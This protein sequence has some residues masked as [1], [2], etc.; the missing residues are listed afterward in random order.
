MVTLRGN[1]VGRPFSEV[2]VGTGRGLVP[3][4]GTGAK[5]NKGLLSSTVSFPVLLGGPSENPI[6]DLVGIIVGSL[7]SFTNAFHKRLQT[8]GC[9]S[10]IV[11]V[12][13]KIYTVL[14]LCGRF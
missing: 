4:A 8:V 7:P 10:G 12:R 2:A 3:N 9:R 13:V 1:G 14:N 6:C 5:E 11:F